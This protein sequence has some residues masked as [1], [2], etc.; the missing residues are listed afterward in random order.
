MKKMKEKKYFKFYLQLHAEDGGTEANIPAASEPSTNAPASTPTPATTP[1]PT[2]AP[3]VPAPVA[4]ESANTPNED[5]RPRYKIEVDPRTNRRSVVTIN[6]DEVSPSLQNANNE[7]ILKQG[8]TIQHNEVQNQAQNSSGTPP[9]I[10]N[11]D[12]ST[13]QPATV[14][15][16]PSK[17]FKV[18][19]D[20]K[21][22]FG[23]DA[24]PAANAPA[25]YKNAAEVIQ[26]LQSGNIDESRIPME[27]AFQYA[28][29]KQ[30]SQQNTSASTQQAAAPSNA[31]AAEQQTLAQTDIV[32]ARRQF[33]GRVE[34]MA[35]SAALTDVGLTEEQLVTAEY[36]DDADIQ[37]KAAQYNAALAWHRNNILSNVQ[38]E[39][40][41]AVAQK[42]AQQN[43]LNAIRNTVLEYSNSEPNFNDINLMMA[44]YYKTMPYQD[45]VRFAQA[46]SAF[47]DGT[48]SEQQAT[49]L[50]DYYNTCRTAYYAN[51]HNLGVGVQGVAVPK[52]ESAGAGVIQNAPPVEQTVTAADL[53]KTTDYRKRREI[54][55]KLFA[56]RAAN[57]HR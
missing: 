19:A 4:T 47:N 12:A 1:S 37:A 25:P 22:L 29:Y 13:Q 28:A 27:L 33:F 35:K 16:A 15:V 56:Q 42:Q 14:P 21:P 11:V 30:Q 32:T 26:A 46:I 50:Q 20:S 6:Y 48:I 49:A 36:S 40:A 5:R 41:K 38:Q 17:P 52:V 10:A 3:S 53:A 45:A 54:I 24:T 31:P 7:L 39:Q 51:K 44:S 9:V 23:A 8:E 34:D 2:P 57:Q 18:D 55:G 43:V